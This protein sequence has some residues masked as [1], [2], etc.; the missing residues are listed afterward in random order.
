PSRQ[1]DG[2]GLSPRTGMT[3]RQEP[4]EGSLNLPRRLRWAKPSG[5]NTERARSTH[6]TGA[7]LLGALAALAAGAAACSLSQEG[8]MPPADTLF[9]PAAAVMPPDGQWLYV[10][11]SNADLRYNDGTLAMLNVG[12]DVVTATAD[13]TLTL[14]GAASDRARPGQWAVC[15]QQD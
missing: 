15:P 8:V 10:A 1:P 14:R 6:R 7:F 9:F 5:V 3:I 4:W 11:N 12:E 13:G 2:S